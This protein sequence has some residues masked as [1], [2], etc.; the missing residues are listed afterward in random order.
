[1]GG[2]L[3]EADGINGPPALEDFDDP[4]VVQVPFVVLV[5]PLQSRVRRMSS[6][7]YSPPQGGVRNSF[8]RHLV[9]PRWLRVQLLWLVLWCVIGSGS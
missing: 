8:L 9:F 1:M 3:Q 7:V 5:G 4:V 2:H 6:V